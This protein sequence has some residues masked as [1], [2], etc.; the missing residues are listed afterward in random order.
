MLLKKEIQNF[1]IEAHT[2]KTRI[3]SSLTKS[4]SRHQHNV[5]GIIK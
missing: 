4:S 1:N 2:I 5:F 3:Q